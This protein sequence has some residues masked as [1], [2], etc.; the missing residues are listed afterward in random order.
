MVSLIVFTILY[1]LKAVIIYVMKI[2]YR[3]T[4][5]KVCLSATYVINV[6]FVRF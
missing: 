2:I 6:V 4:L 3:D 1:N 5:F